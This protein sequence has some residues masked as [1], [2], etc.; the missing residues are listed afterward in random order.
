M[1]LIFYCLLSLNH[2]IHFLG[3]S[4][5]LPQTWWF[6]TTEMYTLTDLEVRRPKSVSLGQNQ[7]V[8]RSVFPL[9]FPRKNSFLNPSSFWR[10]PAFDW[11]HHPQLCLCGHTAFFSSLVSSCVKS[12][13]A[14]LYRNIWLHLGTT[15]VI[16]AIC[17]FSS[18]T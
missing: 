17:S 8:G 16:Q 3:C 1:S 4:N 5:Q 15:W 18:L 13:L 6:K 10:L 12:S 7:A 14:L 9:D 2:C 11:R